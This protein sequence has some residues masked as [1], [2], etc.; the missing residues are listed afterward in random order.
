MSTESPPLMPKRFLR[1]CI[2]LL[3]REDPAHGYGLIQ[4]LRSFGFR[5]EDPG[6]LYR[7]LRALEKE[8]LVKS[9]WQ[10]S[11]AGP[12]RRIYQVTRAGAEELHRQAR[13]LKEARGTLDDFLSRY[14]EFVE[15]APSGSGRA[16]ASSRS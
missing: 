4:R 9:L 1:P 2:L 8:G 12:H 16:V 11:S 7:A 6:G 10:E 13:S 14:S 5:K 15:L 3:L